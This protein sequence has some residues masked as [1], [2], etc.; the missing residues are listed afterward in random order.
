MK[1]LSPLLG[2]GFGF[3]LGGCM[4]FAGQF[5]QYQRGHTLSDAMALGMMC[6]GGILGL[7]LGALAGLG[8]NMLLGQSA[9]RTDSALADEEWDDAEDDRPRKRR[10]RRSH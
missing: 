1:L 10:P 6:G 7:A 5:W 3:V 2:G 4:G 9:P 8:L